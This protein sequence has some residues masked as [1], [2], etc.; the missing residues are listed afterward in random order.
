MQIKAF[1]QLYAQKSQRK[2]PFHITWRSI[3]QDACCALFP[4]FPN[5]YRLFHQPS[6]PEIL[7]NQQRSPSHLPAHIL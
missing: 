5:M 2:V 7:K 6:H 4:F 3:V 1:R